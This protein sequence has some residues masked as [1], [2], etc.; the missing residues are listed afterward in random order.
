MSSALATATGYPCYAELLSRYP[1]IREFLQYIYDLF[2]QHKMQKIHLIT[3]NLKCIY[4][5][6]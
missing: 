4:K 6:I 1:E 2:I 5:K 3:V